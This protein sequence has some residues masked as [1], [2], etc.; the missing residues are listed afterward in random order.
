[1][2]LAQDRVQKRALVLVVLNLWILM[3]D[4]L[5]LGEGL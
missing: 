5:I 3:S 4:N 1:M 2:E